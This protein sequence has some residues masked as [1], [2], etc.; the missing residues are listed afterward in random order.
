MLIRTKGASISFPGGIFSALIIIFLISGCAISGIVSW[1]SPKGPWQTAYAPPS[2]KGPIAIVLSGMD[3]PEKYRTYSLELSRKGYYVVLLDGNDIFTTTRKDGPGNLRK[4]VARA[5]NAPPALPGK[6][7]VIGFSLGGAAALT[8]AAAMPALVSVIVAYYPATAFIKDMKGYVSQFQVPIL[9][10]AGQQDRL[11]SCCLAESAEEM[12]AAAKKSGANFELV[13]YP[14][15]DHAFAV[16]GSL[17]RPSDAADA[18]QRT[19]AMLSRY[20][21]VR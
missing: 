17:Y 19:M 16:P 8:H 20:Q 14:G 13:I 2:G 1:E 9:V 15:A 3:G 7:A 21:P 12:E 6:A 4:A 10:M 11:R 5:Q 18:W